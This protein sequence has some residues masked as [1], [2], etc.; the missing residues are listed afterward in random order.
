LT[1]SA[2]DTKGKW[3][4]API[5]QWTAGSAVTGNWGGSAT[6]VTAKAAKSGKAEAATKFATWLNT[7]PKA[8]AS[9]VKEA[10]VYPA[11]T[12]AQSSGALTTPEFFAN[13]P[14]F[15]QL[16][17][18]IAKGTAAAGWGPDVNVA[19]ST[20]KD[21]FGKAAMEKSPFPAALTAVQQ[22]TVA[23]MKKNGFKTEG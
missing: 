22:A 6:G 2:P 5:P 14:D 9:L 15:Y 1:T 20:F 17:A 21:A 3:R 8:I 18:D 23:D 13:Q 10:G 19:Y 11:A 7:D 16:A 4:M 12:A